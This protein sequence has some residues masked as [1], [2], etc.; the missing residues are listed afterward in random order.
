MTTT[1]EPHAE[2]RRLHR[3]ENGSP[4]GVAVCSRCHMENKPMPK[5]RVHLKTPSHGLYRAVGGDWQE[6]TTVPPC[7][8]RVRPEL[9]KRTAA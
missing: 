6:S 1:H 8:S 5:P 3:W 9:A 2:K 7:V 4:V